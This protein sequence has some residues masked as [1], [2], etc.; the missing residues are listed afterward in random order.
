MAGNHVIGWD[1]TTPGVTV[2][3]FMTSSLGW[4]PAQCL[5]PGINTSWQQP[6][7][8][9]LPAPHPSTSTHR[10]A[11]AQQGAHGKPA[12]PLS[13]ST[14][15]SPL[16]GGWSLHSNPA[17]CPSLQATQLGSVSL[18]FPGLPG[19]LAL[20]PLSCPQLFFTLP[21]VIMARYHWEVG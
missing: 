6:K 17:S 7:S 10:P 12:H 14:A 15:L 20:V 19:N 11:P 3:S 13:L 4:V 8:P 21:V 18:D 2:L 9:C 5:L 1:T 16:G